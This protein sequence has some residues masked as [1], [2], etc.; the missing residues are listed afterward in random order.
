[1]ESFEAGKEQPW[2]IETSVKE[3][4]KLDLGGFKI[5]VEDGSIHTD[6]NDVF[7]EGTNLHNT[8]SIPAY[9]KEYKL[10][11]LVEPNL[12][13]IYVD[14]GKHCLSNTVYD[15]KPEISGKIDHIFVPTGK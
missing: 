14:E 9:A 5:W 2:L 13:E 6:R 7:V 11:I 1:M 12:I 10:S 4:D 15:L 3:G 8:F